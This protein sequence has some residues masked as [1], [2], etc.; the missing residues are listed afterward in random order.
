[1]GY[2]G[3]GRLGV[4]LGGSREIGQN[5]WEMGDLDPKREQEQGDWE[6]MREHL[7]GSREI[8][9][10][11]KWEMGDSENEFVYISIIVSA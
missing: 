3:A 11:K 1:M 8:G 2:L 10:K 9:R 5:K 6:N 7:F 4:K